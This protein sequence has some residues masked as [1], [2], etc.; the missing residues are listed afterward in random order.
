[1][2]PH[3]SEDSTGPTAIDRAPGA[4][5]GDARRRPL[6]YSG[7]CAEDAASLDAPVEHAGA[8]RGDADG[9]VRDRVR[10]R[11]HH[12]DPPKLRAAGPF[13]SDATAGVVRH[14]GAPLGTGADAW[15]ALVGA[16]VA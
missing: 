12:L 4:F 1:M 9:S 5:G 15:S 2:P 16:E 8:S 14:R 7:R 3:P 13:G 10:A 6:A 11:L